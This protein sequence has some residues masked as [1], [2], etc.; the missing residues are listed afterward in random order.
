MIE[1]IKKAMAY[2]RKHDPNIKVIER[3]KERLSDSES[4]AALCSAPETDITAGST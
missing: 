4:S 2:L 1:D 3:L